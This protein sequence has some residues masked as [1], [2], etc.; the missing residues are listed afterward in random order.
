[1]TEADK[2][3]G[4]E[5]GPPAAPAPSFPSAQPLQPGEHPKHVSTAPSG[6]PAAISRDYGP[7]MTFEIL[8]A[9]HEPFA[10]QPTLRFELG[11]SEP[12]GREIYAVTLTA[13]INFDPARRDYDA[14]TK[15][16]LYELFGA[17]ERWPS[18]TRS[19]LWTHATS[20]VHTFTGAIT[21]GMEVPCTAD[22]EMVAS[23]YIA[24]LPDGEVPLSFHFT[25]RIL[26]AAPDQ[27]VQVV[28][29]PW[30]TKAEYRM[31]V[32]VWRNMIKHHHGESGFVN[33][34]NDTLDAL[35]NYKRTRGLHTIDAC[36]LDL[37]ERAPVE[38]EEAI[39]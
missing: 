30:S 14:A 31:P 37:I 15:E 32:S 23:R 5:T 13:Q 27:R 36:V 12:S 16:D 39:G 24:A 38:E 35:K 25:G 22:L 28:H 3:E 7:E 4:P 1:M 2:P 18:T 34:H 21:F 26:Y 9:T 33:L 11:A 10:A 6:P 17:P 19:F 29:L 20:L 8:G